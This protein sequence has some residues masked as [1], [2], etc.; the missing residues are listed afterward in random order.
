M[1]WW[2][3]FRVWLVVAVTNVLRVDAH[4]RCRQ[5]LAEVERRLKSTQAEVDRLRP[6]AGSG[7]QI[8]WAVFEVG[9]GAEGTTPVVMCGNERDLIVLARAAMMLRGFQG[10]E[11]D[12]AVER[13]QYGRM[14]AKV[15]FFGARAEKTL[16][17]LERAQRQLGSGLKRG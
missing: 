8:F 15:D 16:G 10:A 11:L 3:R 17:D 9:T 5:D 12:R 6:K 13:L 2:S 4:A 1:K 14:T 7:V